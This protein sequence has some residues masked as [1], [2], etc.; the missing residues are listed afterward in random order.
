MLPATRDLLREFHQ[1]FNHKLAS[2]LDNKAFLWTHTWSGM[3]MDEMQ[4][5]VN[6]QP[7]QEAKA[8]KP[9][10]RDTQVFSF[11]FMKCMGFV[12]DI[13]LLLK[14]CERLIKSR[15][16]NKINWICVFIY[17]SKGRIDSGL[18]TMIWFYINKCPQFHFYCPAPLNINQKE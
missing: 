13:Y 2:V 10:E 7:E 8:G 15:W 9:N 1:P 12:C 4:M 11:S 5:D 6:E 17:G 3:S 14:G 16:Y 18:D